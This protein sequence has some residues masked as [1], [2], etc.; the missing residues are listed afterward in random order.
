[1]FTGGGGWDLAIGPSS[2]VDDVGVSVDV[3]EH[4][5][6]EDRK[7]EEEVFDTNMSGVGEVLSINGKVPTNTNV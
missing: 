4:I 1:M 6:V 3:S 2:G 5:L 7:G